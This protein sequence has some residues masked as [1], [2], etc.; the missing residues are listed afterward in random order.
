MKSRPSRP[1]TAR[2]SLAAHR[3]GHFCFSFRQQAKS[4][5]ILPPRTCPGSSSTPRPASS[6]VRSSRRLPDSRRTRSQEC[7]RQRQAR[8]D[9][10]RR[11]A[12][13]GPHAADGLELV[14]LL[15]RRGQRCKG[16]C[17]GRRHGHE[18]PGGPRLPIRQYRR[19]L[20]RRSRRQRRDP[21]QQEIP[22][23]EGPG[24]LRSQQGP[25]A[26]H[27]FVAG[28]EDLRRLR[29]KLEARGPGRRNLRQMGRRLPEVRLVLLWQDR[30]QARAT[31]P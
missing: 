5:C 25:E 10:R 7:P 2:G 20:G 11:P 28:A 4:R 24:R 30:P 1:F 8:A 31:R 12:Q 29:S 16:P 19:L 27:L 23:H 22:R 9:D 15:G 13:T 17:R 3:A 18:R 6:A 21:D 26:G 14:E